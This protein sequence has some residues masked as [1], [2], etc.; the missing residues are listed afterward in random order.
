MGHNL[1]E[2]LEDR[3]KS[4]SSV[5]FKIS[6]EKALKMSVILPGP[7]WQELKKNGQ[8]FEGTVVSIPVGELTISA[9]YSQNATSSIVLLKYNVL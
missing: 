5:N 9:T 7:K 6:S 8:F 3:L 1:I 4:G 2:P